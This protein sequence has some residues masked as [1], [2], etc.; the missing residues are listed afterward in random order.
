MT[1]SVVAPVNGTSIVPLA[2]INAVG[3]FMFAARSVTGVPGDGSITMFVV[4]L[5]VTLEIVDIAIV[6]APL[7]VAD[8]IKS[9]PIVVSP[10]SKFM[11]LTKITLE[12]ASTTTLVV[13]APVN[14]VFNFPL[15]NELPTPCVTITFS[16]SVISELVMLK[17]HWLI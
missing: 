4:P 16:I 8:A 2:E 10:T 15:F 3:V 6:I 7:F 5:N 13:P 9:L 11:L 1:I 17:V 14:A 12:S